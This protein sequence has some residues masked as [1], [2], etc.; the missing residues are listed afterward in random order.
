MFIFQNT[1]RSLYVLL[2]LNVE[3]SSQKF[4]PN[5]LFDM[6]QGYILAQF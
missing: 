2:H 1:L 6:H 4:L 5:L 3:F